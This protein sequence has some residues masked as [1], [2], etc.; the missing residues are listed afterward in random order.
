MG[1]QKLSDLKSEVVP[2]ATIDD[3]VVKDPVRAVDVDDRRCLPGFELSAVP[4]PNWIRSFLNQ[5]TF[6][7]VIGK[8][9]A[10]FRFEI[11][12]TFIE[13]EEYEAPILASLFNSY[14]RN[15]QQ[16]YAVVVESALQEQEVFRLLRSLR[17]LQRVRSLSF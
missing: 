8:E 6:Q 1:F 2:E 3:R 7:S 12:F 15:A 16:H 14:V 10:N 5:G 9:L 4:N 17:R 13:A 11:N